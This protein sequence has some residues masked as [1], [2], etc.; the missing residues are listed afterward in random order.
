MAVVYRFSQS[1]TLPMTFIYVLL[2][3]EGDYNQLQLTTVKGVTGG[4]AGCVGA[5]ALLHRGGRSGAFRALSAETPQQPTRKRAKDKG[6]FR[7]K[8]SG[9][10]ELLRWFGTS[11]KPIPIQKFKHIVLDQI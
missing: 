3:C 4:D 8:G 1:Y 5:A 10:F 11:T 7:L 6:S 9:F 2:R